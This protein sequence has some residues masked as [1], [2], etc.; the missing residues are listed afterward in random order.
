MSDCIGYKYI[1]N[2]NEYPVSE[3]NEEIFSGQEIIYEV[4]RVEEG[5]PLFLKDH[6]ERLEHTLN[7]SQ[8]DIELE[9]KTVQDDIHNLIRINDHIRG[10][11]K[12]L[13][14]NRNLLV[15]LMKP[16]QPSPNEY[17]SGVSTS[18]LQEERSN[19]EA[20]IWN[21]QFRNKTIKVLHE[22]SVFELILVTRDGYI[23][24]GS[25]SNVFL[26]K[27]NDLFTAPVQTV[28]PGITRRKVLNVCHLEGIKVKEQL[29]SAKELDQ[30]DVMF[31]QELH[32]K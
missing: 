5:I 15:C 30:Y 3:F 25:R 8:V 16:Y 4:F 14:S 17:I 18:L 26:I 20:K 31:L 2:G 9:I 6:M 7:L 23:T 11:V 13:I 24:E 12:I 19:P 21:H 27:G 10:P 22:R 29:I 28:L 1:L 32:A